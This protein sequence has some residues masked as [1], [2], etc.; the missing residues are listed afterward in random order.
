MRAPGTIANEIPGMQLSP[1][2]FY[3]QE[4]A[5][6]IPVTDE[7][8]E[9]V[10]NPL[11]PERDGTELVTSKLLMGREKTMYNFVSNVANFATGHSITLSGTSQWSDYTNSDPISAVRT[12]V[13]TVHSKIFMEPNTMILPYQVYSILQDHPKLTVRI[14]YAQKAILTPDLIAEIFGMD[15]V[16]V[17]GVGIASGNPGQT[18]TVSYLWGKDVLLAWVPPRA[19]L[20]IPAFGYEFTW[21]YGAT[22]QVVDRWREDPRK[23]DLIRV[24]RRYDLKIVGVDNLGKS[25]AGYLIKAAV[26]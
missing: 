13:R 26:A 4:H 16:I 1:D 7:E 6:Q 17:P 3:A 21:G 20:K 12:G 10:D 8:R 24:Q 22:P 9:I 5:L 18:L 19:G 14:Q 2:T 11:S 25:I 15:R 23:S